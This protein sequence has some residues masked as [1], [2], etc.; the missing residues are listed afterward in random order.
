MWTGIAAKARSMKAVYAKK[1]LAMTFILGKRLT[2]YGHSILDNNPR[3]PTL[4]V[5]GLVPQLR[6]GVALYEDEDNL[7]DVPD[8]ANDAQEPNKI[9]SP[10]ARRLKPKYEGS[11]CDF[12]ARKAR[13]A[14]RL[15][16]PVYADC[17]NTFFS[18]EGWCISCS[19]NVCNTVHVTVIAQLKS[20]KVVC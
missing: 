12:A 3:A 11:H 5:N 2:P 20:Y 15:R 17:I 1:T 14:L 16:Y 4:S 18:S 13:N 8:H 9:A 10:S 7:K 6:G 19:A